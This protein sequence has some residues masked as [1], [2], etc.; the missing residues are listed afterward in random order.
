MNATV[1]RQILE[2]LIDIFLDMSRICEKMEK[3]NTTHTATPSDDPLF[4]IARSG[5]DA[6]IS[7]GQRAMELIS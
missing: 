7:S 6:A 5:S 1:C 3:G 4:V 2:H